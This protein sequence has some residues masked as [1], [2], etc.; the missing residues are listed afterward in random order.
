VQTV[1]QAVWRAWVAGLGNLPRVPSPAA[2]WPG[3]RDADVLVVG[4][5]GA[6]GDVRCRRGSREDAGRRVEV[7]DERTLAWGRVGRARFQGDEARPW[8]SLLNEFG[9]AVSAL[10]CGGSAPAR[11]AAGVYGDDVLVSG[12]DGVEVVDPRATLVL[13][14]GAP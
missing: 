13:A 10:R 11:P 5:A 1:M 7:L 3:G 9:E 6:G 4:P 8:R 12:D 14:P 2:G